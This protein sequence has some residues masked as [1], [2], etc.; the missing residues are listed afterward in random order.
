ME[1]QRMD[2][3][4]SVGGKAALSWLLKALQ[5]SICVQMSATYIAGQ[6]EDCVCHYHLF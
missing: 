5:L 2:V 4:V 3:L 1:E 6:D